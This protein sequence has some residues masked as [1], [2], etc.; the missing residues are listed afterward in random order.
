[1]GEKFELK[2]EEVEIL[3]ELENLIGKTIPRVEDIGESTFGIKIVNKHIIQLKI[4][5][6]VLEKRGKK[7]RVLPESIGNLKSLRL[8][9][10][11]YNFIKEIPESIGN[12]T[13]LR[14]LNF[15]SNKIK[16]VPESI[17]NLKSLEILILDGNNLTTNLPESI[18]NLISLKELYLK[19]SQ[20]TMLPESIGNL[21]SLRYLSLD[22]NQLTTLP[23][24]L[25]D[26]SSLKILW[27]SENQLIS[28][29][30]SIGN[31]NS[32]ETL[33]LARNNLTSLPESFKNLTSLKSLFLWQT[34]IKNLPKSLI[35][36]NSLQTLRWGEVQLGDVK[37]L[38]SIEESVSPRSAM[39]IELKNTKAFKTR[40]KRDNV[41][42]RRSV[43]K[44]IKQ[45]MPSVKEGSYLKKPNE[46]EIKARETERLRRIEELKEIET[47]LKK[48]QQVKFLA[49]IPEL[50]NIKQYAQLSGQS[51]SEFIRTAIRDKIS[52]LETQLKNKSFETQKEIQK[53]RLSFEELKK[54]RE[55][56]ERFD[57]RE[58]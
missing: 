46:N 41:S 9:Y 31:L 58:K 13:S 18:G 33:S 16:L 12:L 20:L 45:T 32:L 21:I 23:E 28:L 48:T 3:Q 36:L 40:E 43:M 6:R 11:P 51:Q 39:M 54:I 42:L 10:L 34:K 38:I 2:P 49:S 14:Y 25:G 55:L 53:N 35:Q 19:G 30:E 24:S 22:N 5:G 27:L 1:M 26:L 8:L 44:E 52:S 7:L 56:L 57:K 37:E 47:E 17:G 4:H 15:R 50:E 29:P